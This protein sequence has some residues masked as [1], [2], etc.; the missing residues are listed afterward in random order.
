MDGSGNWDDAQVFAPVFS[1]GHIPADVE[2]G[3][4]DAVVIGTRAELAYARS[5]GKPVLARH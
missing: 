2:S 1:T 4:I 5:L 3:H